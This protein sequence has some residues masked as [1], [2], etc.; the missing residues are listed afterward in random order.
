MKRPDGRRATRYLLYVAYGFLW[1]G[2]VHSYVV[3]SGPPAPL[4]W[5]GT[6]FMS[7]AAALALMH[8]PSRARVALLAGGVAGYLIEVLGV[9][10]GIPF[11]G[12]HYTQA[13]AP[14][15][16]HVPV[17]MIAAWLVLAGYVAALLVPLIGRDLRSVVLGA[18]AL[19]LIDFVLDP[20]A[21]G[22]MD[23]W[24]W[25]APGVYFGIPWTNFAGWYIAGALVMAIVL[26]AG[27]TSWD[28]P[29]L[30][31]VGLSIVAFFT[32]VAMGAGLLIPAAVGLLLIL[33]H[34]VLRHAR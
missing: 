18:A 20:V 7:L 24:R 8:S 1:V 9:Y 17:V 19:T 27:P 6:L 3:G 5:V 25:D 32:A 12:Y 22:P 31:W 15:A 33:A 21:A 23:L 29:A 16:F 14:L 28:I 2:G 13:F 4:A 10:T 26:R 30:R 34:A 11:G